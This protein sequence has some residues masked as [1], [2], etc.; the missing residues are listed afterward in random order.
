M[1]IKRA[2]GI[3]MHIS[4]LPNPYGIGTFGDSAYE[5]V[6]FLK[7]AKQQ[8]WQILPL[9]PTGYAD[10]PYQSC[11][12][13]AINPYFIDLDYLRRDGLLEFDHYAYLN[14]GQNLDRVDYGELYQA[15]Y[16]VLR[17]AFGRG[18]VRLAAE[19]DRFR[20]ENADWLPDYALFMP[21]RPVASM[22][23]TQ[24][25]SSVPKSSA[26]SSA[27]EMAANIA[28]VNFSAG[29]LTHLPSAAVSAAAGI[30]Q[31]ASNPLKWSMRT[32]S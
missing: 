15:R 26:I 29:P 8:Y 10:S 3:V 23:F 11:S 17:T 1:S 16:K 2:S 7:K 20:E 30:C 31:N 6:D 27:S 22:N 12:A 25:S 14:F 28:S 32:T 19:L 5:F 24:S 18:R 9:S 21:G 4:S 13:A